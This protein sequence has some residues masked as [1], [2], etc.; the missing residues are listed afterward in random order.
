M[1]TTS[2]P[3]LGVVVPTRQRPVELRRALAAI[4]AQ[5][6]PEPLDVV[7]VYD[8]VPVDESVA[9]GSVRAIP[10]ARAPGLAGSRNTGIL[11]LGTE[12]VAFCDDDDEWLPGKLRAQVEALI[13]SDSDFVT[14]S[15]IV[16]Y[17]GTES[18]R[19]AGSEIVTHE[20]LVRSR[21][22]MLHSSTFVARRRFLQEIGLVDEAIPA[23]QGEDWDLLLRASAVRPIVHVDVPLAR[24]S[25]GRSSYFSRDWE[26][27]IAALRW[28]LDRHP[29]IGEEPAAA[30]RVFGQ[31][32][33]AHAAR[34]D[35]SQAIRWGLRGLAKRPF[36]PRPYLAF[37]VA[38]RLTTSEAVL[39]RLHRR[40]RGV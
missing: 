30:A 6:Y 8:G 26:T 38:G 12:L 5:D 34:G 16:D 1:T 20:Q 9:G 37:A 32:A 7:V 25:W 4:V 10:N 14:S 24:I 23:G 13:A 19:L 27:K 21:M 35:A 17:D 3:S 28:M 18:P 22:S 29:E 31:L 39:D 40:G 15:V 2:W 33:F 11:S 36:E